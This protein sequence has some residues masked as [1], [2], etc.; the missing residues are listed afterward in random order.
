MGLGVMMVRHEKVI[1]INGYEL[2]FVV[3]TVKNK[4]VLDGVEMSYDEF[5]KNL[6]I[7]GVLGEGYRGAGGGVAVCTLCRLRYYVNLKYCIF[8]GKLL[9]VR[10][11]KRNKEKPLLG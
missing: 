6:K 8:C 5:V 4:Y 7:L 9:R 11:Y 3:D 10:S 1:V 2:R